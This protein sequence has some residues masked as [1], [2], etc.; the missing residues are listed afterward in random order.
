[1]SDI[2]YNAQCTSCGSSKFK[3]FIKADERG[4]TE[5]VGSECVICKHMANY[6]TTFIDID[7]EPDAIE[8][9]WQ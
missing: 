1:M 7:D 3:L 2:T 4:M 6:Q 9:Y 5:L 8:K